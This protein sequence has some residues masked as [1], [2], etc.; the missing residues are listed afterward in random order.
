MHMAGDDYT[1]A[2]VVEESR[3]FQVSISNTLQNNLA[4]VD[5]S[6]ALL[7]MITS[8]DEMVSQLKQGM[9]GYIEPVGQAS[10]MSAA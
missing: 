6:K 7:D 8:A 3:I 2:M 4:T 9:L 10:A 5:F 1:A